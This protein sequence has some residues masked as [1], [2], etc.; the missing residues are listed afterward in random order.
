MKEQ[1][2]KPSLEEERRLWD[3]GYVAVAG[4]DEAGRG[5]WAGPVVAAAVVLPC[6]VDPASLNGVQDSKQLTPGQRKALLPAI[7]TTAQSVGV[8]V[9]SAARID[10][11]GIVLATRLAMTLA[12][13]SLGL[14][15]DA[16]LLDYL[17]LPE[18]ELPQWAFSHG[19][20]RCLTIAAASVVAKVC[21]DCLMVELSH[22]YPGYGFDRHKGYGTPQHRAA[23]EAL[24][25]SPLHRCSFQPLR[26][27]AGVGLP[28]L[29]P[30]DTIRR[31][32]DGATKAGTM[33]GASCR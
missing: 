9:V 29:A 13:Q 28:N 24:G 27:M 31:Y 14:R 32:E 30:C 8:G 10:R 1:P 16:L 12:I 2:Q 18:V 21:R 5:P 23:L 11:D 25:P 20:A 26:Q 15:P 33:G 22:R 19:D 17:R 6:D 3:Q 7:L 4:V